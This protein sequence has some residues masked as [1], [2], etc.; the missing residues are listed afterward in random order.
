LSATTDVAAPAPAPASGAAFVR[1]SSGLVKLGTP[2]RIL[3]M[4][5][6]VNGIGLFMANF[7][8]V[9]P[10]TFPHMN[11]V[12]AVLF[13]CSAQFLFNGA[14]ALLAGAFPR[15]GGEYVYISR[16]LGPF[17]GFVAN[18]GAYVAFCF[19][20]A[21]GAFLCVTFGLSPI[22]AV[23]G[24]IT[25]A[26]WAQDAGTWL[27]DTDHALL[28]ATAIVIASTVLCCFSMRAYYRYQAVT[29]WLG[30]TCFLVLLIVM[31]VSSHGD[32]VH[33]I[34]TFGQKTG[35]G[36]NV[37]D[38][39]TANAH[40]AGVPSGYTL[41]ATLSMAA[42]LT[43]VTPTGYVGGEVRT[44]LRTQ[45]TGMLG[46][47]AIIAT[48]FLV[49]PLLISHVVGLEW[50]KEAAFLNANGDW[51]LSQAPLY[52]FYAFLLTSSPVL[53][54]VMGVGLLLLTAILVPQQIFMPTRMIFAWSFD[55]LVPSQLAKVNPRTGSP[56]IATVF[57]AVV[58]EALLIL[59]AKGKI[60]Y[61]NPILVIGTVWG[62][63]GLTAFLFP[64]LP[65]ARRQWEASPVR[66]KIGGIP[67]LC[68][69]GATSVAYWALAVYLAFTVDALGANK[70]SN[71]WFCALTFAIPMVYFAGVYAYRQR[72]GVNLNAT[73]A[74]LPPD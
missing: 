51:P 63:V 11:L 13:A 31:A 25:D 64:L 34:N 15:S 48:I 47:T 37:Y 6:T 56:V 62:I 42:L 57:T 52:T 60:G 65:R 59:F 17:V 71:L 58:V 38:A 29:W 44:P 74:E 41:W 50:N 1:Q 69:I 7:Y 36:A 18:V 10:A 30:I 8:L 39:V 72:Q 54:I 3:V 2:W 24:V 4:A 23:Y 28:V 9:G 33:G 14:Y 27:A 67:V 45:L 40:K 68:I 49:V 70:S 20:A 21:V 53:L 16:V 66:Y 12:L 19:Y 26:K 73:F 32:F 35:A 22:A 43:T 46:G 55:R 61:F 5:V